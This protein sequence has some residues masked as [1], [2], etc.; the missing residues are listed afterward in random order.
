MRVY[1]VGNLVCPKI[2]DVRSPVFIICG[3]P[4]YL[5]SCESSF[6]TFLSLHLVR[7]S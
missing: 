4:V 6:P 3:V 5:F 7:N 2:V 1:T